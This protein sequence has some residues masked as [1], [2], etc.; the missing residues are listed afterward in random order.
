MAYSEP[1]PIRLASINVYKL[2]PLGAI[3]AETHS[4]PVAPHPPFRQLISLLH[5]LH[6]FD[7]IDGIIRRMIYSNMVGGSG[8][9]KR[10]PR[11][12]DLRNFGLLAYMLYRI[13]RIQHTSPYILISHSNK[14]QSIDRAF[15]NKDQ[16]VATTATN[17]TKCRT[18]G[19]P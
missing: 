19:L 14:H 9:P 10:G 2:R 1:V 15:D 17:H 16:P 18:R 11:D 12:D 8:C 6:V 7:T 3:I 4:V 5:T 13:D